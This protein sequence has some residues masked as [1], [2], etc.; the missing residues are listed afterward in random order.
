[1]DT[2]SS[3]LIGQ[4]TQR[5]ENMKKLRELGVNPYPSASQKD[6]ENAVVKEKFDEYLDRSITLAGRLIAK[7]EHGKLIF[8]DILDQSGSLQIAIKK[9]TIQGNIQ[10]QLLGWSEL[11]LIDIGDFVQVKG[12][13]N[14]TQQGEVTLFVTEFKILSKCL[15][16][17]PQNFDDKEMQFRRRYVDLVVNPERKELFKR[18]SM[19]WKAS[20]DFMQENG[21][22]EV[23]TPVLEHV[24]GGADARP[25]ITHHNMLDQDFYLR[26]STEL[27]QKRLVGGGFEKIYTIGPNFRNEGLSDEHL[28]EFYQLEWYWAYADYRNNMKIVADLFKYIAQEVYGKTIFESRGHKFDLADDWKEVDYVQAIKERF[29]VDIFD[30]SEE[31]MMK[32]L[33]ECGV[34]L[35]GAVN[36]NRLIDNLWKVIRKDISGPAFLV[37]EPAFMSP[38]AKAK[39]D[40]PRLTERFHVIIAGSELGNGYTEINDPQYQLSQ[41]LDQQNMRESGDDEAQMLDIDYVEMLEYGMPPTSGYG[42][43]ER[44]FWFFENVTSREGTL[45]PQLRNEVDKL[46]KEIYPEVR[47]QHTS[48]LP[49]PSEAARAGGQPTG[50][51]NTDLSGL[52]TRD[53]ALKLLEEH[54]KEPYQILH[55]KMTAAG[56][57]TYAKKYGQNEDLWY[58]TGLLHDVDYF[59]YPD[60]H[61]N[62]SLKWFGEWGYPEE[63][64]HAV[65]AHAMS[66]GRTETL[67]KTQIDFALIAC[68]ELS[69]LLY[70]YSLMRPTGFEGMEAKSV[71]KKFKDKAFAAKIDREEI[72]LGVEGLGLDL[73]EHMQTLIEVFSTMEELRR[74]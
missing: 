43:S 30:D 69:G 23:E 71:M 49:R 39:T 57:E 37:N 5:I 1:M 58:I 7:R 9:D 36:R 48:N 34:E 70:A 67:P 18:K 4:R 14:K 46:T 45:F 2:K 33:K 68:D 16:P 61:P 17:F 8:G 20:R 38:L 60:A 65:S 31:K 72:K 26:I 56:M 13:V 52:P 54:V 62:E 44:I 74:R 32:K 21:F 41:F 12:T 3:D 64:I 24:T 59:E 51:Q 63:M 42:Q 47:F 29:D 28:Q 11:K 55:A 22:M 6:V 40:D 19:F 53:E 50:S 73:K 15:R 27:Y 25:F 35:S 10:D 66:S